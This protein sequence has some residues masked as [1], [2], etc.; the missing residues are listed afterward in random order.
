MK[1]LLKYKLFAA[2]VLGIFAVL[3]VL[4]LF[5][6]PNVINLNNCKDDISKILEDNTKLSY[7]IKNIKIVTSPLLKAGVKIDG[8]A[9]SYP[10]GEKIISSDSAVVKVSL[11]PL[12]FKTLKVSDVT[13][14]SPE[15]NLVYLKDGNFDIVNYFTADSS[16]QN[17][18]SVQNGTELPI[19]IASKLPV[20]TVNNYAINIKDEKTKHVLSAKGEKFVIDDSVINKHFSVYSKG[21]LYINDVKNVNYDIKF[22]SFWPAMNS[23]SVDDKEV[24]AIPKIDFINEIVKYSPSADIVADLEAKEHKG[25]VDLY[26]NLD[27][28]T[29]SIKLNNKK[30]PDSFFRLNSTGHNTKIDSKL[31][32]NTDETASLLADIEHSRSTKININFKTDKITFSSIKDFC[33]ALLNSLNIEN[34]LADFSTKGYINADFALNTDL[35]KFESSGFLKVVDGYISHKKVPVNITNIGADLDFSNNALNIKKASALVNSTKFAMKGKIDS[36]AVADISVESGDI[37]IASIFNAFAPV[38]IKKAYILQSGILNLDVLIKGALSEV[39]PDINVVLEKLL[40]KDRLGTFSFANNST[41]TKIK[42]KTVSKGIH[43]NGNIT[44]NGSVFS[45]HNPALKISAPVVKIDVNQSDIQIVPFTV[46]MNSSKADVSGSIKDYASK[47]KIDIKADASVKAQD[48][49]NL[50]PKEYRSFIAAAG[51]IPVD[52]KIGGN[53][54]NIEL[55]SQAYSSSANYFAPVIVKGML[56]KPGFMNVALS[57]ADDNI[58]LSDASLYMAN[59]NTVRSDFEYNK[60]GATKI[61][62]ISG[63]VE[64][65][66]SSH[67]LLKLNFSIPQSVVLSN[68]AMPT[69]SLTLK[70]DV[71]IKGDVASPLLKGF[72]SVKDVNIPD[73]LTKVQ[74][75]D[76]ELNEQI[77]GAKIQN[78]DI[79]GTSLNIDAEAS[80]K[81]GSVFLIKSMKITSAMF[82]VDNIFKAMDKMAKTFPAPANTAK[83]SS[84]GT[85]SLVLPVKIS[86]GSIDFQ[87]LKMKQAGG[88]FVA[89]SILGDFSI[90]NDLFKLSNLKATVYDGAISGNVDYNIATTA[91]RAKIKGKSINS[92]SIVTTFAALKDQIMG[93]MDFDA[94]LKLKGSTYEQQMKSLNG[95]VT[96]DIKDGQMGSLGRL[97]TFLKADNLLSQSFISTKVGSL[98]NTISPYNTGKFSYLNGSLKIT[99]G[100]ALLNPV[101]MSGPN[102]S[103]LIT[104]NVNILSMISSLQI[105]GLL[106]PAVSKA[107]GPIADVSV[108]KIASYLPKFGTSI[109]NILNNYNAAMNKAELDKIPALTPAQENCQAFRVVLNG[110]LNN[111]PSTIKRFQWLNTP[112]AIEDEQASLQ[113]SIQ[114]SLPKTKEELK[115]VVKETVKEDLKNVIEQNE[116]V[117]E[118][119]QNKAVQTFSSIYKF[120]KENSSSNSGQ[121]TEGAEQ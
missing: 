88:D 83:T 28:E 80:T 96:F 32:L 76:L 108:S 29:L 85:K 82:D 54:K 24:V 78:L 49:K 3:Y 62:G 119:K 21:S 22:A 26:G 110:N 92:N 39:E 99:N 1:F 56:N 93:N 27:V 109:S 44:L 113:N 37:N 60:K 31:Y 66:S 67:P 16:S 63:V 120:Y 35:K 2:I 5:V 47:M 84:V 114:Q 11:L 36:K 107:L 106:S 45:I 101:K 52:V 53:D 73:L 17:D 25:H 104:G 71:A 100:V 112:E 15:I 18:V 4:F 118:L 50:L 8:L 77:L 116:K 40:L 6:L 10:N 95:N 19:K 86:N 41:E 69:S 102:M 105:S 89:N 23:T 46:T 90:V 7:D 14:D 61:T 81:L 115:N 111:P 68:V 117:Q 12:I 51:I 74:D 55:N 43:Y 20:V 9:V 79:S 91:V 121:T 38:D 97:E 33:M 75:I 87:K 13:I 30:L 65:V 42:T 58:N 64:S 34:D 70:G 59:K 94:D 48:I 98:V 57:Y 103:L 72:V